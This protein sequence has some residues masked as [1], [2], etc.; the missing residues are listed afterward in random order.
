MALP[1]FKAPVLTFVLGG[2][3]SVWAY[4]TLTDDSALR[5]R[6]AELEQLNEALQ[7]RIEF[8]RE[9]KR[10]A[11][12]HVLD[13]VADSQAPGGQRT[14]FRFEEIDAEGSPLNPPREFT[15]DGDVLYVDA[16][17]I[18]FDDSFLQEHELEK[19]STLLLFRRLFG[20]HQAPAEGFALAAAQRPPDGYSVESAPDAFSA[21]LWDNFWDYANRPEVLERTGVRA[22]HGEAPYMRLEAGRSYQVELRTTDGLT[23]RPFQSP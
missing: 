21:E 2:G 23:I 15:I 7:Q 12:I 22:M 18:K 5:Q 16:Q 3:L 8:L 13:Q 20:E 1:I 10:V 6:V 19:G 4:H 9:R 17:V 14:T 11:R